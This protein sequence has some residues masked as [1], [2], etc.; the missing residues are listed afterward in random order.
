MRQFIGLALIIMITIASALSETLRED[1]LRNYTQYKSPYV[2]RLPQDTA[3]S[4]LTPRLIFVLLRG[5]RADASRNV[6]SLNKL[7]ENGADIT[8]ELGNA[9]SYL[10]TRYTYFSGAKI[11]THGI[12]ANSG[13]QGRASADTVFLQ[14]LAQD[15]FTTIVGSGSWDELFGSSINLEYSAGDELALR[16]ALNIIN[17]PIIK[18]ILVGLELTERT[19]FENRLSRF[20]SSIDLSKNTVL[21]L[22]DS[23]VDDVTTN[24]N[25]TQTV[26]RVPFVL[27]GAGVRT[28]RAVVKA[29]TIAPTLAILLGIPIPIHAEGVPILPALQLSGRAIADV[30]DHS[31]AQLT[32]FYENWAENIRQQRFASELYQTYRPRL[33]SAT[34]A[35][36]LQNFEIELTARQLVARDNF[37]SDERMKRLPFIIGLALCFIGYIGLLINER[38]WAAPLFA[39]VIILA[40]Y[41]LF[42]YYR[43]DQVGFANLL[44][45]DPRPILT[46]M[47][48]DIAYVLL[49]VSIVLTIASSLSARSALHVITEVMSAIGLVNLLQVGFVAWF[50]WQWG[51]FSYVLPDYYNFVWVLA[52]LSQLGAHL[53]PLFFGISIPLPLIIGGWGLVAYGL[54]RR[55]KLATQ[56]I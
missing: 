43:R 18:P 7:R 40:S 20:L 53:V 27:A 29:Q 28:T 14:L 41:V 48:R 45:T 39:A 55:K 32:T 1:I 24:E 2:A 4:A 6:P 47:S 30:S 50:L 51:D 13:A 8:L 12:T 49:G 34:D 25:E 42:F 54:F 19:D 33:R 44:N 31:A 23:F 46:R 22:G 11:E 21:V 5:L 15:K 17:D 26:V 35:R 38:V 16:S 37:L 36:V 56:R 10:P 3:D 9:P 52:A